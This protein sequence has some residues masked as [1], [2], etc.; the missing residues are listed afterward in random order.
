[1]SIVFKTRIYASKFLI[2]VCESSHTTHDTKH[3]IIDRID[4]DL[5]GTVAV[6]CTYGILCQAD[7]EHS[8]VDPAE[9][10]S[11]RWLMFLGLESEGVHVN[12][13]RW[14]VLVVLIR[15]DE[16]ELPSI[17]LREPIMTVELEFSE[18]SWV[19]TSLE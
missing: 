6:T 12:S 8:R 15:L 17:P 9:I 19:N 13:G 10:A 16:I 1:M 4:A 3:I 2:T 7:V 14:N 5:G 11:T 18:A